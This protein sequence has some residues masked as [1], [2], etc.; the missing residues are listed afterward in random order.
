MYK[1]DK[2]HQSM[3]KPILMIS[4]LQNSVSSCYIYEA[5]N[6]LDQKQFNQKYCFNTKKE[7]TGIF[8]L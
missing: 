7:E 2:L 5:S 6:K 4:V 3:N 8:T 1:E